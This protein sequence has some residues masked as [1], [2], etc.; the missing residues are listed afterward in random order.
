MENSK[1]R[2]IEDMD[3]VPLSACPKDTA[4]RDVDVALRT[5]TTSHGQ[6]TQVTESA[7][8]S[9][10]SASA[11]PQSADSQSDPFFDTVTLPVN[12]PSS[13][14]IAWDALSANLSDNTTLVDLM[15]ASVFDPTQGQGRVQPTTWGNPAYQILD[16]LDLNFQDMDQAFCSSSSA[17][18][19]NVHM[20]TPQPTTALQG[21]LESP[22]DTDLQKYS[23]S[24]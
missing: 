22:S 13:S 17:T 6:Q 18:T 5:Q 21:I 9:K 14:S 1:R 24:S 11:S 3:K 15:T 20:S 7:M 12:L 23:E 10:A 16:A 2:R 19:E 4:K 8:S